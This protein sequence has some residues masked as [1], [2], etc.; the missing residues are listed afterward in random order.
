[1]A[2]VPKDMSAF[3]TYYSLFVGKKNDTND[4]MIY[5]DKQTNF[6]LTFKGK[7]HKLYNASLKNNEWNHVCWVWH[8]S[9]SW[10]FFL[11]G[12]NVS[13][14]SSREDLLEP[15]PDSKGN[16][17]LGQHLDL[18]NIAH[19][20]HMFI[21]EMTEFFIYSRRILNSE[22]MAAYRSHAGTVN[23]TVAWWQ[24]QSSTKGENIVITRY[25]F[26]HHFFITK[27]FQG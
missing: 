12:K 6:W 5:I 10:T 26:R 3:F 24:F 22:V 21:G 16:I 23:A 15:F 18:G 25:P 2:K 19:S 13:T 1:M 8:Y 7:R 27:L 17:I 20:R 14:N 4:L 9:H 11:N